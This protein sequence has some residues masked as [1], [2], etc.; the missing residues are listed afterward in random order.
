M[1]SL[2]LQVEVRF[3]L[4]QECLRQTIRILGLKS[5]KSPCTEEDRVQFIFVLIIKSRTKNDKLRRG[6]GTV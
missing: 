4:L 2:K 1:F 3:S 5:I 6:F